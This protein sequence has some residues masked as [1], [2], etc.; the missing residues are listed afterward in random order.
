MKIQ[1]LH[2]SKIKT[3]KEFQGV[4]FCHTDEEREMIMSTLREDGVEKPLEISTFSDVL[5]DGMGRFEMGC[6]FGIVEFPIIFKDFESKD[7]ELLYVLTNTI[8]QRQLEDWQVGKLHHQNL[9]TSPSY[10]TGIKKSVPVLDKYKPK[11]TG[12]IPLVVCV[13]C[14]IFY[15]DEES[16]KRHQHRRHHGMCSKCHSSNVYVMRINDESICRIC[17]ESKNNGSKIKSRS[18]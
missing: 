11:K 12:K 9:L 15:H 8:S 17:F 6:K 1:I 7:E 14:E 3:S 2:K 5:V 16:L 10:R 13:E 18:K 4:I